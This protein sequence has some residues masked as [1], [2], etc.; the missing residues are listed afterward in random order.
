VAGCRE[1]HDDDDDDDEDGDDVRSMT[2][3]SPAPPRSASATRDRYRRFRDDV[4]EDGRSA[5]YTG[6]V[7]VTGDGLWKKRTTVYV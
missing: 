2:T 7:A 6:H 1:Q 4:H 5:T 3:R